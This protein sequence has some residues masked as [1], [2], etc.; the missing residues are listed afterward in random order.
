[1]EYEYHSICTSN[2]KKLESTHLDI[3]QK[4]KF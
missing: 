4:K 1:M 2:M 3:I